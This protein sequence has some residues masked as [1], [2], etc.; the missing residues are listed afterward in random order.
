[1]SAI[2]RQPNAVKTSNVKSMAIVGGVIV[3]GAV[4]LFAYLM[5][6]VAPE[7]NLESVKVVAVTESGCIGETFDGYSVNIGECDASPGEWVTAYVDQK[8]KERA[9]LMNPTN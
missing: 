6:Y 5:W 8:A 7:E 3:I 1:M 9:A 4:L 2:K